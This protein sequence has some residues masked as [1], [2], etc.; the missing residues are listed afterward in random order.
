MA[1]PLHPFVIWPLS[2]FA[3]RESKTD[4]PQVFRYRTSNQSFHDVLIIIII[5]APSLS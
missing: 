2:G 3:L 5:M 1:C 4:I